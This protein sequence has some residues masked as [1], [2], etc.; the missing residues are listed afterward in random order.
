MSHAH[1]QYILRS[2]IYFRPDGQGGCGSNPLLSD[3]G[4]SFQ[5]RLDKYLLVPIEVFLNDHCRA[6]IV[7]QA[8]KHMEKIDGLQG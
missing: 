2:I 7:E 4:D 5:T 8:K 6:R 3:A 1:K